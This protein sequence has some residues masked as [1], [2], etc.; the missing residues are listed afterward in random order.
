MSGNLYE[1]LLRSGLAMRSGGAIV[2]EVQSRSSDD[3]TAQGRDRGLLNALAGDL[4]TSEERYRTLF[5]TM[6]MGIVHYDADGSVLGANRAAREILGI[7]L[8]G[9]RTWPVVPV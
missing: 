9:A 6:P 7:D 4:A 2:I 3:V 1:K 5:E 8:A